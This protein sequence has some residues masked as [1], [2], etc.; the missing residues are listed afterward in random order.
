MS[1]PAP[2]QNAP[3]SVEITLSTPLARASGEVTSVTL[4]KPSAG[5]LRGLTLQ[6][7][8]QSDVNAMIALI[9]RVAQPFITADEVAQLDPSDFSEMAGTIVGFF[10]TPAQKAMIAR[11]FGG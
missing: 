1:E 10:Y 2:A 5:E 3:Q 9:P 4:R 11:A 8:M 6:D 7:I